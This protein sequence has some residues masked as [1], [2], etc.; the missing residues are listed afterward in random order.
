[1]VGIEADSDPFAQCMVVMAG[2]ERQQLRPAGQAQRVQELRTPKRLAD[3]LGLQRAG[4]VMD[5][6][7]RAQQDRHVAI[8][9]GAGAGQRLVGASPD[10]QNAQLEM[11]L[12]QAVALMQALLASLEL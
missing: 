4:I 1:M 8:D 5:Y 9:A 10:R 6:V 11:H 7:V 2:H 3:D 12:R